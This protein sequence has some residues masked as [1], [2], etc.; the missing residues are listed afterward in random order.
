MGGHNF[1]L[2][3]R[4]IPPTPAIDIDSDHFLMTKLRGHL[5]SGKMQRLDI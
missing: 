3:H 5:D 4:S 2:F 1:E